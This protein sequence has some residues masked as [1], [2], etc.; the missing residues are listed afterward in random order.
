VRRS[1]STTSA[2]GTSVP[3]SFQSFDA[4][5]GGVTLTPVSEACAERGVTLA[6]VQSAGSMN[7]RR[8]AR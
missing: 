8:R 1:A 2:R 6:G 5:C 3:T 7:R 4:G